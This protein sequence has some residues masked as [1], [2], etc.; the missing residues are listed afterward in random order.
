MLDVAALVARVRGN[1]VYL[2]TNIFIY[3]LNDTPNLAQPCL[4]L[5]QAC[6]DRQVLGLT[7]D[8]T[9][10]ELLVK[11]LQHNNAAAVAAVRALLVED[12]AIT[13]LSHDRHCFERAAHLRAAHGLKMVDALHLATAMQAGAACFITNDQ[14]FPTLATVEC[15]SLS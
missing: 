14:R 15:L 3:V 11:P 13:L 6:A 4:A 8:A 1:K 12:G 5:L 7:G 9:L 10:A 2:D